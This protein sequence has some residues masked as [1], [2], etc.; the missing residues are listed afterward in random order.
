MSYAG[1]KM[2]VYQ[3]HH[4]IYEEP[5]QDCYDDDECPTCGHV[6][7]KE[8]TVTLPAWMHKPLKILQ[9]WKP[10][11]ERYALAINWVH[12]IMFEVKVTI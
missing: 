9:R 4:I 7:R 1:T 12:S 5:D 6:R 8:W 10:T 11:E 3:T 2:T